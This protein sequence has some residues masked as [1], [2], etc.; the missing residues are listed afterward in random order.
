MNT[1]NTKPLSIDEIRNIEQRAHDLR[2]Q[3]MATVIHAMGR[4]IARG[5]NKIGA[6]VYRPRHT[7][8]WN[9]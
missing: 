7:L 3:A 1:L 2:A 4:A 9:V 8:D 5:F 6:A